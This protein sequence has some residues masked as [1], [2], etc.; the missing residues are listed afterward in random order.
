MRLPN[1]YLEAADA[2]MHFH[3]FIARNYPDLK[4][5]T[6]I[7]RLIT[8]LL[9]LADGG[10]PRRHTVESVRQITEQLEKYNAAVSR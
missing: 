6:E 2:I 4:W 9:F 8:E 3:A 10:T 7:D 5:P 1:P